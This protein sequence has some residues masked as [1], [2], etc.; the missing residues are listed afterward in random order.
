[1]KLAAAVQHSYNMNKQEKSFGYPNTRNS[2][3]EILENLLY[4]NKN[5]RFKYPAV[6]VS[7]VYSPLFIWFGM[8]STSLDPMDSPLVDALQMSRTNSMPELKDQKNI[9]CKKHIKYSQVQYHRII[10][11]KCCAASPPFF[12]LAR[13]LVIFTGF[14]NNA[15]NAMDIRRIWPPYRVEVKISDVSIDGKTN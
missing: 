9:F 5:E 12:R 11:F 14:F 3:S 13:I 10:P 1:M 6:L 7:A 15:L 2:V 8:N 4:F